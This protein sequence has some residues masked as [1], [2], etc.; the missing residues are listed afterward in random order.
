MTTRLEITL[1][2]TLVNAKNVRR[3]RTLLKTLPLNHLAVNAIVLSGLEN[4]NRNSVAAD[5]VA[6]AVVDVEEAVA[7]AVV[8]VAVVAVAV[9]AVA[10]VAV[11]VVAVAVVAV[12]VEEDVIK[13]Q[14]ITYCL[15]CL[16]QQKPGL[17]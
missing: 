10:V 5:A 6:D 8:A 17:K 7:E 9:V 3:P 13:Y 14:T 11:A 15:R 12:A 4:G 1:L 16:L 2:R